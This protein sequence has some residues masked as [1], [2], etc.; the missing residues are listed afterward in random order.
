M[1]FAIVSLLLF[2]ALSAS[3]QRVT[4]GTLWTAKK[5]NDTYVLSVNDRASL[6]DA[7][8]DFVKQNNIKAGSIIGIGAINKATLR[9][10]N[11]DT[12][13]FIDSTFNEQMEISNLT[14]NIS[15]KDGAPYLHLHITLGDAYYHAFAG[16]LLNADIRGAGEFV[17]TTLKGKLKRTFSTAVGLNFYDFDKE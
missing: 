7:I 8:M 9:R 2:I 12:Q 1:K 5:I 17:I 16:H 14:G 15:T 10:Y 11:P 4:K 3:A 6:M 13:K